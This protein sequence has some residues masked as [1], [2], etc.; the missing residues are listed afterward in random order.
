VADHFRLHDL[1][2]PML[3]PDHEFAE[4][5]RSPTGSLSL[6][7]ARW[8]A[9]VRDD[10]QPHTED[11]VYYVAAGRGRLT[12]GEETVDVA[13]GSVAFVAAGVEHRFSDISQDLE[14]LVFW[15]PARHSR[16][17]QSKP[18]DDDRPGADVRRSEAG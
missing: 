7:I 8:P 2:A 3:G 9:G 11:E 13:A 16:A 10:Q 5:F 1:L 17:G 6:T 14:V 18:P 12:I 15:S 4:F